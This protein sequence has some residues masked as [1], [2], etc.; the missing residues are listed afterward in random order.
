MTKTDQPSGVMNLRVLSYM[1]MIYISI[2][3]VSQ[4][5]HYDIVLKDTA[6]GDEITYVRQ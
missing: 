2:I 4:I 3:P 1:S 6:G 5:D